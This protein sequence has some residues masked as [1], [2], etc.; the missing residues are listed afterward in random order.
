[1][2]YLFDKTKG[3]DMAKA[4]AW[5]KDHEGKSISELAEHKTSQEEIIDEIDYLCQLIE[6]DGLNE[7]G[8]KSA[9]A[10]VGI[11]K[12]ITGS[13]IPAEI[14]ADPPRA[15]TVTESVKSAPEPMTTL[16]ILEAIKRVAKII[17]G[18]VNAY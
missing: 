16:D 11:I 17:G 1:M 2:T 10:L 5:V 8:K 18:N 13:D 14:I 15:E 4:K 12:R 3:W 6:T 7:Q 9:L